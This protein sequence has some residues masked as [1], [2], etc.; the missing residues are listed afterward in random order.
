MRDFSDALPDWICATCRRPVGIRT[1]E[2]Q[3]TGYLHP[4]DV[5][6]DHLIIAV[7][8]EETGGEVVTTCDFCSARA[9]RWVYPCVDFSALPGQ[10]SIGAW[11][12]CD[13]CHRL[14]SARRW[15]AMVRRAV[16]YQRDRDGLDRDDEPAYMLEVLLGALFSQFNKHR[17]GPPWPRW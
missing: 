13:T 10:Q 6:D 3:I 8:P 15:R 17:S 7:K 11:A 12:A 2:G 14:I 16:D 1:D 9:P 5:D 4:I